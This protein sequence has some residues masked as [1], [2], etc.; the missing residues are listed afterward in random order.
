MPIATTA[1]TTGATGVDLAPAAGGGRFSRILASEWTKLRTVRSTYWTL[2]AAVFAT[3]A[4]GALIS[5]AAV[6][7]WDRLSPGERASFDPTTHSLRGIFLAQLAIGVL[8]ILAITAEHS[9]GMIRSTFTAVPQRSRV[10]VAKGVVFSAT[11]FAVSVVACFSAFFV[12][13]AILS[14]KGIGTS[15]GAPGVFRAVV[16]AALYL[17][18]LSL[19]A[20]GVGT[21]VRVS[22]GAIAT[23]F[24]VLLVLPGLVD[25]LPSPW[26][27]DIGKYLPSNAGQAVISLHFGAG[28]LSA[29]TGFAVFCLWTLAVLLLAGWRLSARDV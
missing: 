13:Q 11:T 23:L 28:S 10:L 3:V 21:L 16:G 7:R 5:V 25:A 18:V 17:T 22:A 9:T 12:G 26:N 27:N 1:T 24:G 14:E 20:L 8:G 19:F 29:W 6:S 15:I 4:L 2:L